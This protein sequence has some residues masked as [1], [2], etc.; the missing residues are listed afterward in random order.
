MAEQL[1][2]MRRKD[3]AVPFPWSE[4]DKD[5]PSFPIEENRCIQ[6]SRE[7]VVFGNSGGR[8]AYLAS[9]PGS[10]GEFETR[11]VSDDWPISRKIENVYAEKNKEIPDGTEQAELRRLLSRR[12]R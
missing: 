4:Q 6:P 11:R 9:T 5:Q 1:R 12:I 8:F 2:G 7:T 10:P 3:F